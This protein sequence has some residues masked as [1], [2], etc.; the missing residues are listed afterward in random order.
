MAWDQKWAA[1]QGAYTA[2]APFHAPAAP[3]VQYPTDPDPPP[4]PPPLMVSQATATTAAPVVRPTVP[5][6]PPRLM[7]SQEE[8]AA[9]RAAVSKRF[10]T[11]EATHEDEL[12]AVNARIEELE[13][14]IGAELAV[15][16]KRIEA[17]EDRALP[18]E[19]RDA[20]DGPGPCCWKSAALEWKR[21]WTDPYAKFVEEF[22]CASA[23]KQAVGYHAGR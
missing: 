9:L 19:S 12:S 18:L 10:E 21:A 7:V 4:P 17:L 20:W 5:P 6:P 11:L 22:S 2:P 13:V 15:L 8:L 3:V 1:E 23:Y 16:S 14:R